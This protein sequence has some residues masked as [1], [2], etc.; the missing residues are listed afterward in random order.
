VGGLFCAISPILGEKS[1]DDPK[2]GIEL[3]QKIS[4]LCVGHTT[5]LAAQAL[6]NV[7]AAVIV[8]SCN[9]LDEVEEAVGEVSEKLANAVHAY[10]LAA[11]PD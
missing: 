9:S 6:L 10:W 8:N 2:Q 4:A 7:C 1:M 5:K 3:S 11:H